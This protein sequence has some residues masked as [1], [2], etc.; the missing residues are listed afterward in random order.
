[1]N[2]MQPKNVAKIENK[3]FSNESQFKAPWTSKQATKK[4]QNY[5]ENNANITFSSRKKYPLCL[6]L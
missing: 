3:R 5:S 6:Y 2:R 4:K 1:M